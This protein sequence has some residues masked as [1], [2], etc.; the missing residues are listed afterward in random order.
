INASSIF[1]E[2]PEATDGFFRIDIAVLNTNNDIVLIQ[3]V[4]S[5]TSA[6]QPVTPQNTILL[7]VFNVFGSVINNPTPPIV[8]N[9]V[10][11]KQYAQRF[12]SNIPN[13]D[14]FFIQLQP[15]NQ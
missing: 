2:I 10:V 13:D 7:T 15:T 14:P 3:G 9:E 5:E 8:G 6:I 12:F 11:L 4:E 1:I